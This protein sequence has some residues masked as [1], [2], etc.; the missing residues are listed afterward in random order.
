MGVQCLMA[1]YLGSSD[2]QKVYLDGNTYYL[3]LFSKTIITN[4]N[5]LISSDNYILKDL[6]GLYLTIEED[7]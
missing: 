2:K 7:V 1:L 5:V 6:N 3:N 4:N